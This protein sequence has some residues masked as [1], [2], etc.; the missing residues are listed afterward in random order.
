M[1]IQDIKR[2]NSERKI[3]S[4]EKLLSVDDAVNAFSHLSIFVAGSYARKEA[5]E[6][7]DIDLFFI[8]D[9]N[10]NDTEEP[11]IKSLRLFSRVIE[12]AD[13]MNFPKFSND[14]KYLR[15]LEKPMMLS[16]LGG[17]EDDHSNY[18]TARMLM[19]LESKCVF[20]HSAHETILKD[21][22][23]AYFKDYPDHPK[24]FLPTFLVNDILR[25]WKTL[26]LNYENK[27]N[28]PAADANRRIRQKIKNLKL[29]FSRM[30]TCYASICYVVSSENPIGTEDLITM[31]ELTPLERLQRVITAHPELEN[32]FNKLEEEYR[33]FLELTNIS[34]DELN[35]RFRAFAHRHE[36]IGDSHSAEG[37]I[38]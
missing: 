9:G 3:E 23:G 1:S 7:S 25:F 16:E 8:L 18:F 19:I 32:E 10:L 24:E 37:L 14:G 38:H 2:S 36:S 20:G 12:I 28:Q 26:C 34:E 15:I 27:R 4:L 5:S 21:I 13:E 33:W 29:K 17:P 11:N 30:L 22:L 35:R 31:S 6:H